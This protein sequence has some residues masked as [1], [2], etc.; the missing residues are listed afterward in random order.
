MGYDTHS[1]FPGKDVVLRASSETNSLYRGKELHQENAG[2]VL[3]FVIEA[4]GSETVKELKRLLTEKF[5][6]L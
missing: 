3:D 5:P 2:I 4:Y 6:D 1:Q